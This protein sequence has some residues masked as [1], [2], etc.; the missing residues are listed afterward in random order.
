MD[1]KLFIGF[2]KRR[3]DTTYSYLVKE[4]IFNHLNRINIPFT[5]DPHDDFTDAIFAS[6]EELSFFY[7]AVLKKNAKISIFALSCKDDYLIDS[8]N[9]NKISLTQNAYNYYLRADKIY[10]SLNSQAQFLAKQGIT[11]NVVIAKPFLTFA[12]DEK[13]SETIKNA[14]KSYYQIPKNK[15]V[16]ISLGQYQNQEELDLF[17]GIARINPEY[18]F[19]FFGEEGKDSVKVKLLQRL[20]INSNTQYFKIIPEVLY[21]SA[22]FSADAFF[23]PQINIM[24]PAAV[25]DFMA[26]KVPIIAYKNNNYRDLINV[27][28]SIIAN[29]FAELYHSFRSLFLINKSQEAYEYIKRFANY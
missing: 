5:T 1:Y 12:L 9:P 28:T 17:N 15:K 2:D 11:K 8:R 7:P 16:I 25:I 26:H 20:A 18:T 19:L 29:S 27:N 3:L 13:P 21:H 22:L 14:F 10:V 4:N 24:Y 23:I 6:A